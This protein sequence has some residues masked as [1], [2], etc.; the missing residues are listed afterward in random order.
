MLVR[1]CVGVVCKKLTVVRVSC[2]T[3]MC[4]LYVFAFV[5]ISKV[6]HDLVYDCECLP[7]CLEQVYVYLLFMRVLVPGIC[8]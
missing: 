3:C 4:C 8:V 7:S 6:V 2:A 1:I 5:N